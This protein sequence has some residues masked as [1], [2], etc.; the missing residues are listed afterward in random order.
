MKEDDIAALLQT[1]RIGRTVLALDSVDSTNSEA[2]RRAEEGA[3][4]GL[5]VLSEEQTAGR[6]RRGHT[7]SS[8][9]GESLSFSLLLRPDILPDRASQLT[10]IMGLAVRDAL[11]E[12]CG[13]KAQ[14]KW[15]NDIV[16]GGK[17]LCGILTEMSIAAEAVRYIVIGVG[18]NVDTLI[19]PDE[20][21]R[22]AT[23]VRQQTGGTT[24]RALL[25]ASCLR[26]FERDYSMFLVTQDLSRLMDRYNAHLINRGREVRILDDQA[27]S[28]GYAVSAAPAPSAETAAVATGIALG[29]NSG[30]ALLI[31]TPEGELSVTAGEVSVRGVYGYL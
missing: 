23:S 22:I 30:G 2:K 12:V 9:K 15:P 17:K 21:S 24:D 11:E 29:I 8:A 14:I 25:L 4:E 19:F 27:E 6:G 7:W 5:L 18:I 10:L 20:L 3:E 28:V 13:L 31:Q 26:V 1:E 16:C